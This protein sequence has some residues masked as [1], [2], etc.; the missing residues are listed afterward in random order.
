MEGRSTLLLQGITIRPEAP[1]VGFP[2]SIPAIAKLNLGLNKPITFLVGENG[3]G[4]STILEAIADRLGFNA[5]GGSKHHSFHE[6]F[7]SELARYLLL[8]KNPS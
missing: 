1:K 6:E 7:E 3:S 4:K 8:R 5:M 2:F